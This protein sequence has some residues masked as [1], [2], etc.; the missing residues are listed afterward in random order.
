MTFRK[1]LAVTTIAASVAMSAFAGIPLSNKGLAEKLGFNGV[2]YAATSFPN[3]TVTTKVT[4]LRNA[5]IATGGLDEVQTLR[6]AISNLTDT[7]KGDIADPI[8]ARFMKDIPVGNQPAKTEILKEIFVNALGMTYDPNL[9]DLETLRLTYNDELNEYADAAGINNLTVDHIVSYFLLV[10]EEAMNILKSKTLLE[11]KDLL[12][13]PDGFNTLLEGA[14]AAIPSDNSPVETIFIYYGVTTE[15]VRDTLSALKTEVANND[16]FEDAALALY[17][18]YLEMTKPTNPGTGGGGVVI[19]PTETIAIPEEATKEIAKLD[20]LADKLANAT[21]EEKAALIAKAV[22]EA[23]AV[24]AKLSNIPTTVS[25]VGDKATLVLDEGKTLS[26]IAG[27]AAVAESLKKATGKETKDLKITV[28]LGKVTQDNISFGLSKEIVEE[29]IKAKLAAVSFKV[30]N[31]S[32]DVPVGG[33]VNKEVELTVKRSDSS[34]V[35]MPGGQTLVSPVYDFSFTSGGTEITEFK[36]PVELRLPVSNPSDYDTDLLTLA[37]IING[38]LEYYG[39]RYGGGFLMERRDSFSSYVVVEN[40][41]SFEDTAN[42]E[43]WAG[44][45][46]EVV[47]A[48][49]AIQGKSEG[50]FAPSDKVTRAEFAKMLIHALDLDNRSAVENFDDVKSS[51]WFAPYVAAAAEQKIINGRSASKFDP[52]ATI[53][54]A[55]MATMVARALKPANDEATE[56]NLEEALAAFS[57]AGQISASL[58][59]GVASAASKGIVVGSGGK[60]A[61]NATATRAEAA[62]II[63]RAFKYNG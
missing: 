7:Q 41:V 27:I 63:H 5:L 52:H 34:S 46:I 45:A 30:D 35:V 22:E 10:Q 32:I 28:D 60:F 2:V 39:G 18:A 24:V 11:L 56:I 42:V 20:E 54:R 6:T 33:D 58:M 59:E 38:K 53:T 25:V 1:K 17:A 13:D 62:V 14:L 31:I 51:D 55:E 37:K 36:K 15:D 8:V 3:S 19:P 9:T 12:T 26:A 23:Q 40:K 48:K 49:G 61:P 50:V 21:D 29:A 57:D 4:Q 16:I 43:A 44:R 47:A